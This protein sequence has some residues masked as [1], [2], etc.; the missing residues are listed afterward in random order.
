L[1]VDDHLLF[2]EAIGQTLSSMGMTLVGIATSGE[3]A[4]N[5]VREQRPD[6][7]LVD[8]GLPDQDGIALGRAILAEAPDTKVVALTALEDDATM[9]DALRSGFHGYLTKN[10]EPGKFR[11]ALESVSD[12]QVVF[13]HRVGRA[14]VFGE[15]DSTEA[16]LLARQLTPREIEVLQ[17]LAEGAASPVIAERLAV[18]PNTV[19]THVQGILTKLQVHSRLEAAAFAVRHDLVNVRP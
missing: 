4:L 11:R 1:I 8:V 9:Q 5:V 17:L 16:E 14:G 19:R 7:V 6:L 15:N 13:Q 10:S 2:A 18:S 3:K 12:G